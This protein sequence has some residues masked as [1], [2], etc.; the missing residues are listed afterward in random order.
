MNKKLITDITFK[1][2]LP[3]FSN[4]NLLMLATEEEKKEYYPLSVADRIFLV[5][6]IIKERIKWK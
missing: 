6:N 1:D 4:G 3:Y 5:K 2:N